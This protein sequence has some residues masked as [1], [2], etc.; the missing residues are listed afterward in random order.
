MGNGSTAR[1]GRD[2]VAPGSYCYIL[3]FMLTPHPTPAP[4][5]SRFTTCPALHLSLR[6]A[7][8]HTASPRRSLTVM[9]LAM[10]LM[11]PQACGPASCGAG[12]GAAAA[13]ATR[14]AVAAV[15]AVAAA[16]GAVA[17]QTRT[18]VLPR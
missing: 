6:Y 12:G 4:G 11:A 2:G 17:V 9:L 18:G 16:A 15:V 14:T 10:L 13:A 3:P 7:I 8:R 1:D 5:P